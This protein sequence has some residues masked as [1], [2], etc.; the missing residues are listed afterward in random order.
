[1]THGSCSHLLIDKLGKATRFIR[2]V[3]K[4]SGP[5]GLEPHAQALKMARLSALAQSNKRSPSKQR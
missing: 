2:H 1:M 4:P 3:K 5:K